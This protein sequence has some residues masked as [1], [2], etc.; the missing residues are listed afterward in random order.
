MRRLSSSISI[1][2]CGIAVYFALHWGSEAVRIFVSPVHGLEDAWFAKIVYGLGWLLSLS[3][4]GLLVCA[5]AFGALK[6]GVAVIFAVYLAQRIGGFCGGTADHDLL[7]AG[8]ILTVLTIAAL[9]LPLILDEPATALNQFRVPLWL[10]GLAATLTM[11]ERAAAAE[12]ARRESLWEREVAARVL[13][14]NPLPRR[15]GRASALRWNLLRR[16]AKLKFD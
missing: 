3:P 15:R 5:A 2:I 1:I 8:L 9:A 10:V 16:D 12:P 11:V 4:D 13:A 6:L 14:A 7:E